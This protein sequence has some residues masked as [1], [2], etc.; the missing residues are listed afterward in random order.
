V[1]PPSIPSCLA[2]LILL[3]ALAASARAGEAVFSQDGGKIYLLDRQSGPGQ[4][5][6]I[7]LKTEELLLAFLPDLNGEPILNVDRSNAGHIL[8]LTESTCFAWNVGKGA[9]ARVCDAP[10]GGRFAELAY[11]PSTGLI[12]FEV[13]SEQG[14]GARESQL[15]VLPKGADAPLRTAV[16]RVGNFNGLGFD[17]SGELYFGTEGDLWQGRIV[18]MGPGPDEK[19]GGSLAAYRY[20][21]LATRETANSTPGQIGVSSVVGAGPWLYVHLQRMGGSGWGNVVRLAKPMPVNTPEGDPD[22]PFSLTEHIATHLRALGSVKVLGENGALAFLAASPD[23]KLVHFQASL[24]GGE[25]THWLVR[26]HGEP[27]A[28]VI[29]V[30]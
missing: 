11:D 26:D 1:K 10:K 5:F 28:L 20:A 15:W 7:D 12:A 16:R 13:T 27:E 17:N 18:E 9:T 21:P 8:C 22:Y 19:P 14:D 29:A 4:L 3:S 30:P 6:S 2:A 23:G 24:D 25:T